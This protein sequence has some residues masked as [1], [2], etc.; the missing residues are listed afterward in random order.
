MIGVNPNPARFDLKKCRA[1]NGDWIRALAPADL[2]T[3]MVPFLQ[4]DGA[5]P[6]QPTDRQ[7]ALVI[8]AT[9]LVQERIET[10][11][12]AT[13]MLGFLLVPDADLA[14]DPQDREKLLVGSAG[15]ST[16]AI[17][18]LQTLTEWT[19]TAI[20]AALRASLIDGL[21]LKPRQAF[22]AVRVAITGRRVSPPLFESMESLGRESS[23]TRLQSARQL[24]E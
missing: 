21:G 2:A 1:I 11:D 24:A 7:R 6:E 9:P 14:M 18:A 4:R 12:Q 10:L 15:V 22:G 16:A 23:L 13:G 20:E 3:R 17:H 5:L 8:A 19:T